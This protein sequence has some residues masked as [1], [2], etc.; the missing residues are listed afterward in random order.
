MKIALIGINSKYTHKNLAIHSLYSYVKKLDHQFILMEFSIN[1]PIDQVMHKIYQENPDVLAFTTY[2]WNKDMIL[3]LARDLKIVK[4]KIIIVAGGPEIHEGYLEEKD[5]DFLIQGEG[6]LSFFDLIESRFQGDRFRKPAP[7]FLDL[8]HLPFVYEDV[9]DKLE[10]K[11][12]YYEGSR[13]CPFHCSYC[14]SG[15]DNRLRLKEPIKI[16]REIELLVNQGVKQVKF[17]DRTFNARVEW[18]IEIIEGLKKLAHFGCNFHFEVSIDKMD[19]RILELIR[20]SP[21]GLFQ[22][23]I[24]IQTCNE[25]TLKAIGRTNDFQKITSGVGQLLEGGNVHIHTDL[26]AG[27]PC[28]NLQSFETS[29]NKILKLEAHMLQVGFLKVIPNTKMQDE[30]KELGIRYR[31]YPPYEVLSTTWMTGEDLMEIKFVDMGVDG[32]YNKKLFR[33]TFHYL[34]N[35]VENPFKLF[36]NLGKAIFDLENPLSLNNKVEFLY[37]FILAEV[38]RLVTQQLLGIMGLDWYLCNK[39]NKGPRFIEDALLVPSGKTKK[40][41]STPGLKFIAL[42]F[43]IAWRGMECRITES[44][45]QTYV[46]NYRQ[47]WSIYGYPSISLSKSEEKMG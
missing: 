37:H 35:K 43:S 32:F 2:V 19:P 31:Q 5:L 28:E 46:L 44:E 6:E 1:E 15:R 18:A 27:L 33:Q 36:R 30:S 17:I 40:G 45:K 8:N 21:K 10:N 4:E 3:R 39:D 38:P 23:E 26:I 24:G 34:L 11:I 13:G 47:P 16:L 7:T 41:G 42:P 9:M 25:E 29:F 12:V 22:L 20:T 14:L